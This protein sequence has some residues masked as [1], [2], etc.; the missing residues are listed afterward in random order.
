V[1]RVR[2]PVRGRGRRHR[3]GRLVDE[4]ERPPLHFLVDAPDVLAEHADRQDLHAADEQ[5]RDHDRRVPGHVDAPQ[6][7][8]HDPVERERERGQRDGRA[9]VGPEAQ[10][11]RRMREDAVERE[12]PQ[13]PVRP[14]R[15]ARRARRTVVLDLGARHADPREQALHEAD[16]LREALERL[17]RAPVEQPEVAQV[18]AH[19]HLRE[20]AHHAVERVR[21]RTLE[22]ALPVARAAHGVDERDVAL[23]PASDERGNEL[24]RIL[25]VGVDRHDGVA[26]GELEPAGQREILAEVP[27]ES[28]AAHARVARRVVPHDRPGGVAAA[29]VDVEDAPVE[30][31]AGER[32][33]EPRVEEREDLGLVVDGHDDADQRAVGKGHGPAS[34]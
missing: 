15:A 4:I 19:R 1:R 21:A 13:P 18:G 31:G 30:V 22:P 25:E 23:A 16:A 27:R 29:V 32:R 11:H 9:A 10:R 3:A 2:R 24:R 8:A 14:A 6:E 5:D 34:E 7:R 12:V 26:L 17:D 28:H 33:A 20:P